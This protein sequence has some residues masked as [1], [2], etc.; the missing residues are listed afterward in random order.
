MPD[1]DPDVSANDFFCAF[2]LGNYFPAQLEG[3]IQNCL[4][5]SIYQG[6]EISPTDDDSDAVNS[7]FNELV[8][9]YEYQDYDSWP[10]N[11]TP[12]E[13]MSNI[14][15]FYNAFMRYRDLSFVR[16]K[17]ENLIEDVEKYRELL[18]YC[19]MR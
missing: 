2:S 3:I 16:T 9:T 11:L 8:N 13:V 15:S 6:M 17:L 18:R 5:G 1:P 4:D 14:V 19:E 10:G 12:A 7:F